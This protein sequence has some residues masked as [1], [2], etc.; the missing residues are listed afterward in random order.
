EPLDSFRLFSA[1][2]FLSE[3]RRL[4]LAL[5]F[6]YLVRRNP[7]LQSVEFLALGDSD[8]AQIEEHHIT[9]QLFSQSE[10]LAP[11]PLTMHPRAFH[12]PK[13]FGDTPDVALYVV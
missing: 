3:P 5:P 12:F 8:I 7:R 11:V 6:F 10:R 1:P 13:Q 4:F 9:S 2:F